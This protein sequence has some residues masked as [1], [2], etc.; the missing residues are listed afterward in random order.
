METLV[1]NFTR[2]KSKK[3]GR[4]YSPYFTFFFKLCNKDVYTFMGLLYFQM[5][6]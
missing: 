1:A 2:N 4:K 5:L 6:D 3:T